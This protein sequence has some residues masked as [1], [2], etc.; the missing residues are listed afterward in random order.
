MSG[1]GCICSPFLQSPSAIV[2]ER[3]AAC[4]SGSS[5]RWRDHDTLSMGRKGTNR[6]PLRSLPLLSLSLPQSCALLRHL[7][8]LSG[9][10]R[11]G[12][13]EVGTKQHNSAESYSPDV[14]CILRMV[15]HHYYLRLPM[16]GQEE[17]DF[18]PEPLPAESLMRWSD[19]A[20][21]A[22]A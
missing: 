21:R 19:S 11:V 6:M 1:K 20:C 14:S 22:S 9:L 17:T 8:W 5:F 15:S 3:A 2:A 18:E 12:D 4:L 7:G 10:M 16:V 13:I